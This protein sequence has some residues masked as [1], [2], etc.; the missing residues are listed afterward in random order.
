MTTSYTLDTVYGLTGADIEALQP[1]MSTFLKANS[2][3]AYAALSEGPAAILKNGKRTHV[4][5]TAEQYAE[6]IAQRAAL[7]EAA[8]PLIPSFLSLVNTNVPDTAIIP[9]D[10]RMGELR[11]L[12][13]ALALSA[14]NTEA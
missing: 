6:L 3:D 14:T 1:I 12:A 8:R 7:V 2:A 10:V 13:A 5:M 11:K 4:L 9:L